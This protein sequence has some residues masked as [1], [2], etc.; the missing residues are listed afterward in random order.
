[1]SHQLFYPKQR[2]TSDEMLH[3][4]THFRGLR[5]QAFRVARKPIHRPPVFVVLTQTENPVNLVNPV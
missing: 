3:R 5:Q 1:M 2:I 4:L